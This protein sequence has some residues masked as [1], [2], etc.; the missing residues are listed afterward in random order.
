M[1]AEAETARLAEYI[2]A[3]GGVYDQVRII[4]HD[5]DMLKRWWREGVN[6]LAA[7]I[8][9]LI[10]NVAINGDDAGLELKTENK[11]SGRLNDTAIRYVSMHMLVRWLFIVY[12]KLVEVYAAEE[13]A[14]AKEL[15]RLA[16]Y[17]E[18]P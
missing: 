15:E 11:M 7:M 14:L 6:Q 16:Y 10:D 5:A 8:D 18:M 12:P 13:A 1:E 17:R 4:K 3:K 9:T 2:A